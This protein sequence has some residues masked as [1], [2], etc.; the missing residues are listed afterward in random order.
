MAY[1]KPIKSDPC[2]RRHFSRRL[3]KPCRPRHKRTVDM[4]L[5]S[6]QSDARSVGLLPVGGGPVVCRI[7]ARQT[8]GRTG[9]DR[10]ERALAD[11]FAIVGAAGD[12]VAASP[13]ACEE[14]AGISKAGA[15]LLAT[16]VMTAVPTSRA[17][18]QRRSGSDRPSSGR[19]SCNA[20]RAARADARL[21]GCS[22]MGRE[23]PRDDVSG[24]PGRPPK[25]TR[26]ATSSGRVPRA[27]STASPALRRTCG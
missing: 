16:D 25:R 18:P 12:V 22:S 13:E 7:V 9:H 23:H 24:A 5:S 2:R 26:M 8:D 11:A 27:A 20:R 6:R 15:S 19:R 14:E 21:K 17:R 10:K 3:H 4:V 1:G